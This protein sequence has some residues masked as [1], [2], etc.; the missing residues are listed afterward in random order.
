MN[1]LLLKKS[2]VLSILS[3]GLFGLFLL[4]AVGS[5][6]E[7][8]FSII[9]LPTK[10][11]KEYH[12]VHGTYEE[13]YRY[14][15]V[16]RNFEGKKDDLGRWQGEV[17]IT[18]TYVHRMSGE[19]IYGSET[20]QM[21][22]GFR[23]GVSTMYFSGAG[24]HHRYYFHG[25][26]IPKDLYETFRDSY[27][28]YDKKSC[29]SASTSSAYHWL[30]DHY[31]W[32][33]FAVQFSGY[34]S[35]YQEKYLDTLE[36]II[37]AN[38]FNQDEFDVYYDSAVE[39]LEE[40]PYDSII[41]VNTFLSYLQGQ[42]ALRGNE[43]RLAVFDRYYSQA[44]RTYDIVASTYPGYLE[45]MVVEAEIPES[46]FAVFCD[47]MD[48]AMN[49]YGTLDQEDPFFVDSVDAYIFRAILEIMESGE[50]LKS[51]STGVLQTN[52]SLNPMKIRDLY[53]GVS[54]M[55]GLKSSHSTP[56]EVAEVVLYLIVTEYYKGD[57]MKE[58]VHVTWLT[59]QGIPS[60][61]TVMTSFLSHNSATSVSLAGAV[62]SDGGAEVSSRGIAWASHYNPTTADQTV[63]AESDTGFFNATLTGLTEGESYYARAY[64][65]NSAGT[66]Y[67]NCIDFTVIN[68]AGMDQE[69]NKGAA[70]RI[71]PNPVTSVARLH[72]P[73][74]A[75]GNFRVQITDT[76]GRVL[77]DVEMGR[78]ESGEQEVHLDLSGLQNGSYICILVF[79]SGKTFSAK[80]LIAR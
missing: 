35:V 76:G 64:A 2:H 4:I 70:L 24:V 51:G 59:H 29:S 6:E 52:R 69:D 46:D 36:Q 15:T 3:I 9:G 8:M 74:A 40:T 42:D 20:A 72:C 58:A 12:A 50:S 49:S 78:I 34:D 48:S 23:H 38:T 27:N 71:Y 14:S 30:S 33:I 63:G 11:V 43:L 32:F 62:L 60:P 1:K 25:I 7:L 79:E 57:L 10:V 17:Y 68:T 18:S 5:S 55:L 80:L 37:Y 66:S 61:P 54:K 53:K 21:K 26:R 67:G 39:I 19:K 45:T 73:P 65:T 16:E 41:Q 75:S 77:R 44:A 22:D 47:K 28:L 56:A 31:P 13:S